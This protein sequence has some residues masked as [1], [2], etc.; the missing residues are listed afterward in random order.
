MGFTNIILLDA[1]R[2]RSEGEADLL[3]SAAAAAADV[4]YCFGMKEAIPS[5]SASHR[6]QL[7]DQLVC[8]FCGRG[9][10]LVILQN[11]GLPDESEPGMVMVGRLVDAI[12]SAYNEASERMVEDMAG[13]SVV[14]ESCSLPVLSVSW[15][16]ERQRKIE[17]T[18]A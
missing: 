17:V 4:F 2:W 1:N 9:D 6:Q 10:L 11:A 15:D 3:T 7:R 5:L 18:S 8:S 14:L 12:E 16:D 13:V